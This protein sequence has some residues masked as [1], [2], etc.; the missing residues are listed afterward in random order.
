VYDGLLD[1]KWKALGA[2]AATSM[3]LNGV[4]VRS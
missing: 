4:A 2:L 1:N 3:S